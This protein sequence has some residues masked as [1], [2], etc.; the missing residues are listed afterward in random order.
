MARTVNE[1]FVKPIGSGPENWVGRPMNAQKL[2]ASNENCV[3]YH[4]P[5]HSSS[6][7]IIDKDLIFIHA[8]VQASLLPYALDVHLRSKVPYLRAAILHWAGLNCQ[9]EQEQQ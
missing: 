5:F 4:T 3:K 1:M 2:G 8:S 7:Y 6:V 9:S